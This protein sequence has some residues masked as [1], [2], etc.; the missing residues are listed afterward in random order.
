MKIEGKEYR[1]I[2]FDEKNQAVKIIDQ[3]KLPHQFIIKDL[4]VDKSLIYYKAK[5]LLRPNVVP[6]HFIKGDVELPFMRLNDR[7][8]K[9]VFTWLNNNGHS[10]I[11]SKLGREYNQIKDYISGLSNE[12]TFDLHPSPLYQTKYNI[13]PLKANNVMRTILDGVIPADMEIRLRTLG[14]GSYE[15]NIVQAR[16]GEYSIKEVKNWLSNT[17]EHKIDNRKTCRGF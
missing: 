7:I 17:K 1:T 15:G 4:G 8:F 13:D 6:R 3:T 14:V 2:W 16:K 10:D 12:R 9:E 11:T 5:M